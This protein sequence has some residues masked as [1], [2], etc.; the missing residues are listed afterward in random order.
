MSQYRLVPFRSLLTTA[1]LLLASP[2]GASDV[3][4][5]DI[6]ALIASEQG[7]QASRLVR[8]LRSDEIAQGVSRQ[9]S[10]IL[11]R[12]G[13]IDAKQV[14]CLDELAL[15]D[16]TQVYTVVVIEHYEADVIEH[17]FEFYSSPVG[18]RYMR[19]IHEKSWR[20]NPEDFPLPPD[21]P[22]EGL[23]LPQWQE[24]FE[25]KQSTLGTPFADPRALT[26]SPDGLKGNAMLWAV[27]ALQCGVPEDVVR[28]ASS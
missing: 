19:M 9:L 11:Q 3:T 10:R 26:Q 21:R 20:T 16:F 18:A 6:Q 13:S 4:P 12:K 8:L 27:Q 22:K 24:V 17:A 5:D 7:R 25:F 28:G 23:T 15:G 1:L 2:G 14:A